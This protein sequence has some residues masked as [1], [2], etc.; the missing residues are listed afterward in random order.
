MLLLLFRPRKRLHRLPHHLSVA[1][2]SPTPERPSR[3]LIEA[4]DLVP[5]RN[6]HERLNLLRDVARA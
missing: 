6:H 5:N 4:L 2:Q 1:Q 3:V